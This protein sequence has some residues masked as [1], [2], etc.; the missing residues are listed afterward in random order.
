MGNTIVHVW[1]VLGTQRTQREPSRQLDFNVQ[2][3]DVSS[4][5][6]RLSSVLTHMHS[7]EFFDT[8]KVECLQ[9]K[10][11]TIIGRYGHEYVV[12]FLIVGHPDPLQHL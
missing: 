3:K 1:N 5:I 8:L 9:L 7:F 11:A 2:L 4:V 6:W 12:C 10:P